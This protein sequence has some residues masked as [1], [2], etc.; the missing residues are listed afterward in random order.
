M[1]T[2]Q[3]HRGPDSGSVT[4]LAP[5]AAFGHRR[6]AILDLSSQGSQPMTSRD[7]R[8]TLVLNGEIFNYRELRAQLSG[9]PWRSE[10]DTEVLLEAVAAWGLDRA[11]QK[12]IGMFALA[13]W[14]HRERSLL[15]ARDRV[16][17]KPLVYFWDGTIFAFASELKALARLHES[18]IDPVAADAYFGLGYVPAP[19]SIFRNTYKLPAGHMARLRDGRLEVRRW[20]FPEHATPEIAASRIGRCEQLRELIGDAVR[21]RLRADVPIALALSGGIDS[22]VIAAELARQGAAPDAFTVAFDG[23]LSEAPYARAIAQ[24]LGLR[25]EIIEA[26]SQP[27][28]SQVLAAVDQ[29]D[30]PFAD[31]SGVACLTLARA[32]AGQYKVILTGDGG[33]EAFGGYR[34]YEYIGAKQALKAAAAAAGFRDGHASGTVYIQ[35]KTT[36][37]TEERQSL[38]GRHRVPEAL[39]HFLASDPFLGSQPT[40]ALKRALWSDRHLA[41]A[42]GLTYKMDI[43]LSAQG[44]EG[45]A[46]L[47]DHR[48]L[49]WSQN[50]EDRDLV[51]GREKKILLRE[52]YR[53][54]LPDEIMR[55]PK[56]GFGAPVTQ[57]LNGPL[58][59]LVRDALPC[60][61]LTGLQSE[62]A[63]QRQWTLL[64]FAL[65][66]RK[67]RASW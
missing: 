32:F 34:H 50:L 24:R 15:L 29:Y 36:F 9:I 22:S 44:L 58:R 49:E 48:I 25:H 66:A 4:T 33:D 3:F 46:P 57:W 16:G 11:L 28:E 17:E 61:L 38:L 60:P 65:W 63:G 23:D 51:H 19:L 40:G 13:L 47:V 31:S 37:R 5:G 2:A 21:L 6:L 30:E 56:R 12:T 53:R 54:A 62:P 55:R 42:N 45:R 41:F 39:D 7:G 52:T 14:D 35:A 10:T 26:G 64:M 67:W 8:W 20:W 59:E 27:I 18:Q 1:S 43:A